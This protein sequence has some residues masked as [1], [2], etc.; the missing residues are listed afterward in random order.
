MT[1]TAGG[2]VLD[3]NLRG[4]LSQTAGELFEAVGGNPAGDHIGMLQLSVA[5]DRIG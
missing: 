5:N 4:R 3:Q 2:Q 1:G